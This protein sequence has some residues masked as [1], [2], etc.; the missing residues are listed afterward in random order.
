[1]PERCVS[2]A[3]AF[4]MDILVQNNIDIVFHSYSFYKEK[5]PIEGA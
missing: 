1:M 5:T 2:I 3:K 4:S